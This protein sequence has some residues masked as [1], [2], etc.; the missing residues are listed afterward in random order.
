[1]LIKSQ[2]ELRIQNPE[3]QKKEWYLI[4]INWDKLDGLG[5][6]QTR[7]VEDQLPD[8]LRLMPTVNMHLITIMGGVQD[9]RRYLRFYNHVIVSK[10]SATESEWAIGHAK[11]A[12]VD[13]PEHIAIY[14][15]VQTSEE[16]K[17]KMYHFEPKGEIAVKTIV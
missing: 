10:C 1:M 11:V 3:L 13:F 9:Y 14:K 4:G 12:N 15:S 5:F 6:N 2:Y 17:F 16:H 8:L 7:L